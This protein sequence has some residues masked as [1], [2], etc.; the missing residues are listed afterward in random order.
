M[1]IPCVGFSNPEPCRGISAWKFLVSNSFSRF[2]FRRNTAN[3]IS[4]DPVHLPRY[5]FHP[6]FYLDTYI[7]W[8]YPR[9]FSVLRVILELAQPPHLH[10]DPTTTIVSALRGA[11]RSP[12]P[13]HRSTRLLR[14]RKATEDQA[15]RRTTQCTIFS[16]ISSTR[17]QPRVL[18]SPI[19]PDE[20]QQEDR[21]AD[22]RAQQRREEQP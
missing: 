4:L 15:W 11:G 13:L 17:T 12:P 22:Q 14:R 7:S 20:Y 19:I 1:H 2:H 10:L 16:R 9:N 5:R 8:S 21:R 3:F 18:P 6:R